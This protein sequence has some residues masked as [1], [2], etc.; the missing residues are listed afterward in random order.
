MVN[1][2]FS[3]KSLHSMDFI[4]NI[5]EREKERER[6]RERCDRLK[7]SVFNENFEFEFGRC[8]ALSTHIFCNMFVM[9]KI[10]P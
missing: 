4:P 10:R 8:Y 5:E 7:Y 9:T 6:E 3:F 1:F 2:N